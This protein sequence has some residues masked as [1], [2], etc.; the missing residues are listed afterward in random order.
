MGSHRKDEKAPINSRQLLRLLGYAK[1][2]WKCL[3][4]G[5]VAGLLVGG[6][7]FVSISMIPRLVGVLDPDNRSSAV[8]SKAQ[9]KAT[10][11]VEAVS[12][13]G[14]SKNEQVVLVDKILHPEK[15]GS[16]PKL[17]RLIKQAQSTIETFHLPCR[18]EGRI[19]YVDWP[20]KFSFEAVTPDGRMA[21]QI[22]IIYTSVFVA[23]WLIK[24]LAH[25]VNGYC[26]RRVGLKAVADMRQQ[27]F[28]HLL[29]QSLGF[30]GKN[31]VGHLIS[32]CT[33]DTSSMENCISHVVEDL[34]SA[35][36][37]VITCA[38]AIIAA[39]HEYNS[40]TLAVILIVGVP[41]MV[42]PLHFL[43][44]RIKKFYRKSFAYIADVFS[45]MHEAFSG[46]R[47]VIA[48]HSE[49]YEEKRFDSVNRRYL[50]QVLRAMRIDM[51][52]AP[53]MEFMVVSATLVFL[54]VS[55][56][57]GVTVT[58]LAAL[59]APAFLAYKPVKSVS[60]VITLIQRS[61]AAAD[62]YFALL[63]YDSSLPEKPDAV[64]LKGIEKSITIEDVH[65][66]YGDR[67]VLNGVSFE[68][69]RGGMVAVVGETGSGKTTIANLIARFYDVK[70]GS[71]KID[72][73]DVRDMT[74]DSIRKNIGVVT[75]EPILFN[76][77]IAANI[78]YGNGDASMEDIIKAAKLANAH[79]FIISGRHS[80]GYDTIV[81]EKGFKLSGG[82]KQ[83]VAIARAIL[84]NPPIL[85]LDEA[86]SALDTVTERLVQEALDHVMSNRTVFA[87]AHRLSTIRHAD[88]ILVMKD[89][90]IAEH[91]THEELL[92]RNG[93]YSRLH[94][95]QFQEQ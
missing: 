71:I 52:V 87:I 44:R 69:K 17:D 1:P 4:V 47:V 32:R 22:F 88:M 41:V 83:R 14:V 70:S 75:Q 6:S 28:S 92:A 37:Q 86:T 30:Y 42:L 5:I 72:G 76:E 25:Y 8:S 59:L 82:E 73:V 26:T 40:Y 48:T 10:Q 45:R 16:D 51:L 2:Y 60:K 64:T 58:Q 65:F 74:I 38:I 55:F 53:L 9:D 27:L 67:A 7:L 50:R 24:A 62:R 19:V 12:R 35:P 21:W 13:D 84:R 68:I 77:S 81:G 56:S 3:T 94:A 31:D 49:K 18:I 20:C 66:N 85:I 57:Q 61:M 91:G 39:C 36:V 34:T 11:I 15:Y 89:G 29:N 78:A 23:A 80:E 90:I 79:E 43:A 93:I 54:I 46:I 63:D 33:N 95:I